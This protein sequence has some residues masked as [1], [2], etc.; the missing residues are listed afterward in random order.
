M[1]NSKQADKRLRQDERRRQH[2]RTLASAM[3]TAV[4]KVLKAETAEEA[5]AALP[6]AMSRVDKAAKSRVIHPNAADRKK[7]Q[8]VRAAAAAAPAK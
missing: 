7:A 6:Q 3:K 4:K 8:L 1:P 2:N 5:Q